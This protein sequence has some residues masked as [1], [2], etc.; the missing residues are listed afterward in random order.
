MRYLLYLLFVASLRF[1]L[2]KSS[3]P[4]EIKKEGHV[5]ILTDKNFKHAQKNNK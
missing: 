3:S 4:P 5:L 2:V 1:A